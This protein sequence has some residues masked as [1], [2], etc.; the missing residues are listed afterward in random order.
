M[1][2]EQYLKQENQISNQ[3]IEAIRQKGDKVRNEL[4][5]LLI[6]N[7]G[8]VYEIFNFLKNRT[9]VVGSE[10]SEKIKELEELE[11]E[12]KK[13]SIRLQKINNIIAFHDKKISNE[14]K[15]EIFES[16]CNLYTKKI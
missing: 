11:A 2:F 8:D 12:Y 3:K 6:K 15:I 7:H 5:I 9:F 10:I 14:E 13:E 16:F 1:L 4:N